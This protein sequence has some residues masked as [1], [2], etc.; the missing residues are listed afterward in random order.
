MMTLR[1]P[2]LIVQRRRIFLIQDQRSEGG[3]EGGEGGRRGSVSPT[4]YASSSCLGV[5]DP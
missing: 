3:F 5:P 1:N 2:D 4:V